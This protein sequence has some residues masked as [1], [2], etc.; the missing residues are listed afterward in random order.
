MG[1]KEDSIYI[2]HIYDAILRI[3]EYTK[4]FTYDTFISHNLV[5]DGVIRQLMI[6]GE[7]SKL[8]SREVKNKYTQIPW[9]DI[10]GMRD[11]LIHAYFGIDV[12]LV[13]GV[14]EH[15]LKEL[16]NSICIMLKKE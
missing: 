3:E 16:K 7:A 2:R 14:L 12:D 9:K 6:I 1:K 11:K 15:E 13:W 10:A 8:I 5:Q 4:G